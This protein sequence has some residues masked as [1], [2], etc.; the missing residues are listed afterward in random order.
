MEQ[1]L[2]LL[3]IALGFRQEDFRIPFEM[4]KAQF[5]S[6]IQTDTD[7]LVPMRG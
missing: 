1:V 4:E 6:L 7:A 2:V 3:N 5:N